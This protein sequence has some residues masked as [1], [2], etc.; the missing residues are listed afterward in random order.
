[1]LWMMVCTSASVGGVALS[2]WVSRPCPL[3]RT[4][5][6]APSILDVGYPVGLGCD[7]EELES[8]AVQSMPSPEPRDDVGRD[9][10]S[11]RC[12]S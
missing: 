6:V 3:D 7:A 5:S 10:H 12:R 11:G 2:S 1:M 4:C 9:G 8:L